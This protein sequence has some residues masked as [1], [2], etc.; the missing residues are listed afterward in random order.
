MADMKGWYGWLWLRR[1]AWLIGAL[2][3]MRGV[4]LLRQA[5]RFPFFRRRYEHLVRGWRL[6]GLGLLLPL[7]VSL[8]AWYWGPK[9]AA[10][11]PPTPIASPTA[12]LTP[13]P[14]F[15]P[16]APP[17]PTGAAD[18][19]TQPAGPS[20]TPSLS[21]TPFVPEAIVARFESTAT[22]PPEARFSPLTFT[23]GLDLETFQPLHPGEVFQNPVGHMYALYSYD[24]MVDGVQWTALWYRDGELVHFETKPWAGGTGG[25]DY[26]DWNPAPEEW[27]PGRY[28]VYIFIGTQLATQGSFL[29][30]GAPPT[31][32][33]SPTPS[34]QTMLTPTA[35][36]SPTPTASASPTPTATRTPFTPIPTPTP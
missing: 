35:R 31:P 20:P 25:W 8:A 36:P 11:P 12:S 16:T 5:Q 22:P 26:A 2:A 18:S 28:T 4:W 29:V 19:P 10:T 30:E 21:P 23:V 6:I 24:G 3:L 13:S 15:Q 9:A 1:G 7:G 27:L 34:P 17:R 14:T 32:T 33:P